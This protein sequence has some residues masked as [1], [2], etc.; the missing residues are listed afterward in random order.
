MTALDIHSASYATVFLARSG[1][2]GNIHISQWPGVRFQ[3]K[4]TGKNSK[5]KKTLWFNSHR[6]AKAS[7]DLKEHKKTNKEIHIHV[8]ETNANS[9]ANFRIPLAHILPDGDY[10]WGRCSDLYIFVYGDFPADLLIKV[11]KNV[12]KQVLEISRML[13]NKSNLQKGYLTPEQCAHTMT[14]R[15]RSNFSNATRGIFCFEKLQINVF[16]GETYFHAVWA[17]SDPC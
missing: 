8:E 14:P 7:K 1:N 11:S 3:T 5:A 4:K 12:I 6:T 9:C 13:S 2:K 10:S 16:V 17:R 15:A